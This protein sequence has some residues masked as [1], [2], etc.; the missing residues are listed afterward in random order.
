[1][2]FRSGDV[3]STLAAALVAAKSGAA[4]AHV[5]AGLRSFDWTMPEEVNRVVTDRLANILFTPSAEADDNLRREGVPDKNVHCVGNV[6]IDTVVR[7][8]PLAE[9][10]W[11]DLSRKL[12]LTSERYGLVTLHRPT[13]VDDV[14]TL[15]E[16]MALL[17]EVSQRLPL[18]F[19]MHPRTQSRASALA[20]TKHSHRLQLLDP[21]GYIDFLTL[22]RHAALVITDSGGVQE[23]TTYLGTPCFT[24]RDT[25][26][27]PVT[28]TV[29]TNTVVGSNPARLGAAID[30]F[31]S[32]DV[33][34]GRIPP[35]WDGR[36]SD[37]VADVI[38][39]WAN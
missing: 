36:A 5:E 14:D 20:S 3:N 15:A 9:A 39:T 2:L 16:L 17:T 37:R 10:S 34:K 8:L 4:L 30:R 29:G 7:L 26:E 11:P 35:L 24:V 1:V 33:K 23:E 38:D 21:L 27:R 19:P 32:G 25:T 31:L 12:G 22:Q 13:N 18:V 6:M 28:V